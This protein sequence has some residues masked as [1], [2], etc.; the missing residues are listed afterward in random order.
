MILSQ[1]PNNLR[2]RTLGSR[3]WAREANN[4]RISADAIPPLRKLL[5]PERVAKVR[6]GEGIMLGGT[7]ALP[8]K[9]GN[10]TISPPNNHYFG[11]VFYM[12]LLFD[13]MS[14]EKP[15]CPGRYPQI[16]NLCAPFQPYK[17][18]PFATRINTINRRCPVIFHS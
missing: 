15:N 10:S 12:L 6:H 13:T 17:L 7:G 11:S 3:V 14:W 9:T 4:E 18:L 8:E 1:H 5:L 2:T 16:L